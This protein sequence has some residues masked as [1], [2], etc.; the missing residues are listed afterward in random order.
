MHVPSCQHATSDHFHFGSAFNCMRTLPFFLFFEF[1]DRMES[2]V[3]L[4]EHRLDDLSDYVANAVWRRGK[5]LEA[6]CLAMEQ[7]LQIMQ[8]NLD[9]LE[10]RS[11]L[12]RH[13]YDRLER[14]IVAL[15]QQ[16]QQQVGLQPSSN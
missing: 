15:Q 11:E 1:M 16:Q 4:L 9:L 12:L 5:R 7:R 14:Q 10:R 6:R 2:R 8:E 3:S 13:W